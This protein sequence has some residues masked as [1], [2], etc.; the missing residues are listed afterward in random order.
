MTTEHRAPLTDSRYR[1][2]G[3]QQGDAKAC[4]CP[5]QARRL[6]RLQAWLSNFL[7]GKLPQASVHPFTRPVIHFLSKHLLRTYYVSGLCWVH[8]IYSGEQDRHVIPPS[9][10]TQTLGWE[11]SNHG[12]VFQCD[13][14]LS[15]GRPGVWGSIERG[16]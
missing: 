1:L 7:S 8:Y 15:Q 14:C 11:V 9:P 3:L 10:Q 5:L 4:W 12:I 16:P 6:I 13:E 2:R